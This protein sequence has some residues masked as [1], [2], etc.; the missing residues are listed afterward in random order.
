MHWRL[1]T[2]EP[3][4]TCQFEELQSENTRL[5]AELLSAEQA[6]ENRERNHNDTIER[7]DTAE[8]RVQALEAALRQHINCSPSIKETNHG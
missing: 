6:L 1:N 4:R 8:A 5:A 2:E 3:C 7:C